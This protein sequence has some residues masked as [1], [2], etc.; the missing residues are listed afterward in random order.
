M[1]WNRA[2][3]LV[4][5]AALIAGLSGCASTKP[6]AESW[7]L[8]KKEAADSAMIIGHIDYP[9]NKKEN[10][11]GDQIFL[12]EVNFMQKGKAYFGNGEKSIALDNNYYVIPNLKPGVYYLISFRAG[13]LFNR[14]PL[15]EEKYRVELKPGQIKFFSDFDYLTYENSFLWEKTYK[16][17]I[18]KADGSREAE[19]FRWLSRVGA[20][21]GWE[22]AI[23]RRLQELGG[24]PS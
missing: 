18:R 21:S 17:D 16:F 24:R 6:K 3:F 12:V 1:E 10:P 13:E 11:N 5:C 15:Y 8:P 2:A 4:I 19:M 9:V 14:L 7:S 23:K 20:G 22:P